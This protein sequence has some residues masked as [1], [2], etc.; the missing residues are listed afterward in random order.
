MTSKQKRTKLTPDEQDSNVLDELDDERFL[1]NGFVGEDDCVEE[2]I[3][4]DDSED[5]GANE[6]GNNENNDEQDNGNNG[7][8]NETDFTV[9]LWQV[10]QENK[11]S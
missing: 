11:N 2:I 7:L 6:E 9:K 8:E 1:S 4:R 10:F 3:N 5:D